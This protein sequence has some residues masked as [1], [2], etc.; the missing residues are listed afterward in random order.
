MWNGAWPSQDIQNSK[1]ELDKSAELV[2]TPFRDQPDQVTNALA[3]FLVIRTC[4][5]LESV[6]EDCCAA[7]ISSKSSPRVAAFATSW[8]G[9]GAN[10]SPGK[11]VALVR[12]FDQ[13]WADDLDSLFRADDDLLKRE[14]SLLVDKRNKIAH[15][16]GD[17]VTS[18]K[19]LDFITPVE[20]VAAWF[21]VTFDPR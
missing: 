2:R 1:R 11:L 12:R 10:P 7:Y 21:I 6:V 15:G 20:R 8:F 4:G 5:Y 18:R 13:H 19:A 9:S 16:R 17:S 14:I 3:R